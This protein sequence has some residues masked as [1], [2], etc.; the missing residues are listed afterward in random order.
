MQVW[1]EIKKYLQAYRRVALTAIAAVIICAVIGAGVTVLLERNSLFEPFTVGVVDA[2]DSPEA[3]FFFDFFDDTV[4]L[5]YMDKAEAERR[6]QSG[7]I[8]AYAE[9]PERFADDVISG[10]NTPFVLH[11][12]ADYPLQLALT[13]LLA[14]GGVAFL[15]ASQ[16]GVYATIDQAALGGM[17]YEKIQRTVVIPINVEFMSRMFDYGDFFTVEVLPLTEGTPFTHYAYTFAAF[18]LIINLLAFVKTMGGCTPALYARYKLAR[19]GFIKIQLIRL[20][21]PLAVHAALIVPLMYAAAGDA[22]IA[23]AGG[24]ALAFCVSAFGLMTA[25]LFNGET[26]AGMF[27]FVIGVAMLFVSGGVVPLAYLPPGLQPLRYAGIPYWAASAANGH[28]TAAAAMAAMGLLFWCVA[29][30]FERTRAG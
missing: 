9:L 25:A 14:A 27:V 17:P 24:L 21:G 15:S 7:D 29:L 10:V 28:L 20:A 13:R 6:L 4:S 30:L 16:A 18:L 26:A 12:S 8:P 5:E 1:L 11:G 2:G 3:R 19:V 22:L 23:L